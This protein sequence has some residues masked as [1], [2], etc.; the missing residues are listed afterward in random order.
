MRS[1]RL[2][3]SLAAGLLGASPRPLSALVSPGG[4]QSLTL[5]VTNTG[6]GDGTFVL[7]EVDVPPPAEPTARPALVRQP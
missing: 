3:F 1:V 5:D 4:T 7:H 2:D 6:T